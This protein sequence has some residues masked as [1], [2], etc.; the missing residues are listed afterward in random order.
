VGPLVKRSSPER[1]EDSFVNRPDDANQEARAISY[2]IDSARRLVHIQVRKNVTPEEVV[3][4]Y[5]R[6]FS[7]REYCPGFS[8]V[9]NRRGLREPPSAGTVRA[10]VDFLRTHAIQTGACRMAIVTDEDAPRSAWRGAEMLADHYTSVELRVFD[11]LEAADLW[12]SRG[13]SSPTEG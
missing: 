13:A 1:P 10:V 2:V 5:G 12:A 3:Q 6:V 11:D 8:F 4:F 7:A 9:V